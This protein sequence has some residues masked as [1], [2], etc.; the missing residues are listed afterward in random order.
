MEDEEDKITVK[1]VKKGISGNFHCLDGPAIVYSNGDES[2]Y[3]HGQL[4]RD[5]GPAITIPEKNVYVWVKN[6]IRYEPSAH[7]LMIWKMKKEC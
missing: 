6:G 3:R 1:R 7:E 5:D 4:H 2:W